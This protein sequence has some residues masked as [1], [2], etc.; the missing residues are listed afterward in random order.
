[1][2]FSISGSASGPVIRW[3]GMAEGSSATTV[4]LI[5]SEDTNILSVDAASLG[6]LRAVGTTVARGSYLNAATAGEPVCVVGAA[7]AQRLGI[8][9][10][11]AGERIWLG[12]QWFY[13]AG[14]L[15]PAVLAPEIDSSVLVG[16]PAAERELG[17][18]GHPSTIY[19]RAVTSQV[20]SVDAALAATANPESPSEVDVSRPSSALVA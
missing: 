4:P 1:M 14:I 3:S 13:V 2:S 6:L 20:S 9:R 18:D 15:H 16:F 8:D 11:F 10:V 7:A 5:P 17:F 12:G 19:V